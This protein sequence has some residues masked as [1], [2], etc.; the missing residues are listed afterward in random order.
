MSAPALSLSGVS[1]TFVDRH[2]AAQRYTAVRALQSIDDTLKGVKFDLGAA[3]TNEFVRKANTK[4]PK[5]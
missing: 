5:G 4:Y 3:Y 2:D 1:C